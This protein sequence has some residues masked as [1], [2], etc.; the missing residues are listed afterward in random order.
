MVDLGG[1]GEKGVFI[2]S[3]PEL[4]EWKL[5][6]EE[7]KWRNRSVNPIARRAGTSGGTR[8]GVGDQIFL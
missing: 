4:P 6:N 8:E 2:P 7:L 1:R 5:E 3:G